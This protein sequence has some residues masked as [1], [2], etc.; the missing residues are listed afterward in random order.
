MNSN[1]IRPCTVYGIDTIYRV[2][3][4][5]SKFNYLRW[6]IF[7][8]MN[9]NNNNNTSIILHLSLATLSQDFPEHFKYFLNN[10]NLLPYAL[11]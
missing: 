6:W 9:N 4:M 7:L 8:N 5:V 10:I 11:Q 2:R 1:V 3:Y